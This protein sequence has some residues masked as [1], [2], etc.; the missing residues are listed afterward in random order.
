MPEQRRLTK[1]LVLQQLKSNVLSYRQTKNDFFRLQNVYMLQQ[2]YNV[3]K[4]FNGKEYRRY[5]NKYVA[6]L[7][8]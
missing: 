3:Y 7:Y 2:S 1:K 8:K 5:W 6:K 4:I